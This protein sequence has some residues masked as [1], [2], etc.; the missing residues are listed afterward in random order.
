MHRA[1]HRAIA[2]HIDIAARHRRI[3]PGYIVISDHPVK[4]T[5]A[6]GEGHVAG[7]SQPDDGS[8]RGRNG[9]EEM[10]GGKAGLGRGRADHD[11]VR[12]EQR[13]V[14]EIVGD[15]VGCREQRKQQA[16]CIGHDR[17][18]GGV[19]LGAG[20]LVVNR[21][22]RG[23]VRGGI[24]KATLTHPARRQHHVRSHRQIA[25]EARA[26]RQF[27]TA[28]CD[29]FGMAPNRHHAPFRV[30][31]IELPVAERIAGQRVADVVCGQREIA[32]PGKH[33]ALCQR[34]QRTFD[35][36]GIGYRAALYQ[37]PS[38]HRHRFLLFSK[39]ACNGWMPPLKW[40]V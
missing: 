32:D 26:N 18:G 27:S 13:V 3:E 11:L 14:G 5:K 36:P 21:W 2:R 38:E 7:R 15:Q 8:W 28:R 1:Q 22:K 37:Q 35:Q 12:T 29:H 19:L 17:Q 34:W 31:G 39:S 23:T 9:L 10:R 20:V 4:Q 40:H 6:L 33:L 16:A 24:D 25:P 30:L